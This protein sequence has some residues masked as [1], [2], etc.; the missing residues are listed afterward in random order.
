MNGWVA[1][2]AGQDMADKVGK[3]WG[4]GSETPKNAVSS[5]RTKARMKGI[6]TPVYGLQP[7][8]HTG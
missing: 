8:H 7:T 3:V 4:L 6:P 1:N 5:W 2:L